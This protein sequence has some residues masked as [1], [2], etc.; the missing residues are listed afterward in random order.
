MF[1][2]EEL[3]DLKIFRDLARKT[4]A[5]DFRIA[6]IK[7]ELSEV[8]RKRTEVSC[9]AIR[10]CDEHVWEGR[11]FFPMI[12]DGFSVRP[13]KRE[14]TFESIQSLDEVISQL[15]KEEKNQSPEEIVSCSEEEL[16][17]RQKLFEIMTKGNHSQEEIERILREDYESIKFSLKRFDI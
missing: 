14:L 7:R 4:I 3:E 2:P 1:T 8:Q 15:E 9:T 17:D 13:V 12:V 6:D 5:L 10:L 16:A 11:P